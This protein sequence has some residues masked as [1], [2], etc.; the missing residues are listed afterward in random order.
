MRENGRSMVEMLGALAIIGVLSVGAI[1]GYSRA[2][3]KYKL[4]KHA[5]QISELINTVHMYQYEFHFETEKQ[6]SLIPFYQKLN[7]L[8]EGMRIVEAS[9]SIDYLKDSF[10]T[11]NA[12]YANR[13]PYQGE[14][15]LVI[16][17][18]P[19]Y[20]SPITFPSLDIGISYCRNILSALQPIY[21]DNP[22]GFCAIYLRNQIGGGKSFNLTEKQYDFAN[23]SITEMTNICEQQLTLTDKRHVYFQ[24]CFK[25]T[26]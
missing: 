17:G 22:N 10:G 11:Y 8:P 12:V 16:Y 4:N 21:K 9:N 3:M 20:E 5:A 1:A 13:V 18:K 25:N 14:T 15:K 7:A 19:Q 6:I 24:F 23:M 26:K 2:M